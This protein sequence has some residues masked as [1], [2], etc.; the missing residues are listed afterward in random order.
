MSENTS[1]DLCRTSVL[2]TASTSQDAVRQGGARR[3]RIGKGTVTPSR[4]RTAFAS[5]QPS[6]S[7][8]NE[9]RSGTAEQMIL[10][11]FT[12]RPMGWRPK[13]MS[14]PATYPLA[15]C[16]CLGAIQRKHRIID[17]LRDSQSVSIYCAYT[18][19]SM[20]WSGIGVNQRIT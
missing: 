9:C 2:C 17:G 8:Q 6:F 1:L 4:W 19:V 15:R 3:C 18:K 5:H 16:L 7:Y 10:P 13:T 12:S 20:H 11:D 14:W